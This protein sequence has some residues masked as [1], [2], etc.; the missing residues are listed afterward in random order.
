MSSQRYLLQTLLYIASLSAATLSTGTASAD[1]AQVQRGRY[2]VSLGGCTHCHTPGHFFGRDDA[3]RF[4]GGSDVGLSLPDGTTVVGRN[5]TPDPQTGL[6]RWSVEQIVT[7][8]RGGVRPD[9]RI[10]SLVM[11]W[12]N[13]SSL[14]NDDAIAIAVYLKS[15]PA[16]RHDIPGP[17]DAGQKVT[18]YHMQF[19]PM[20]P[21][22]GQTTRR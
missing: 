1:T 3:N 11:P 14:T 4:L 15:L 21:E 2:L 19:I 22:G 18:V 13:Y 6:G 16:V 8:I 17:F 12:V 9:G 20:P 7:A 10:L 5:L